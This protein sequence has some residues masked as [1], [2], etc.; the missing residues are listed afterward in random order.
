M[1]DQIPKKTIRELLGEP[2]P[3]ARLRANPQFAGK[4]SGWEIWVFG[5]AVNAMIIVLWM[6]FGLAAMGGNST[7]STINL[8][9]WST[10]VG[11]S[12]I[13]F[14]SFLFAALGSFG[15]AFVTVFLTFPSVIAAGY[16]LRPYFQ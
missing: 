2:D 8:F 16:F 3:H 14:I 6:M 9:I 13:L 1:N 7:K 10:G 15:F 12:S 11:C 5:V 4:F